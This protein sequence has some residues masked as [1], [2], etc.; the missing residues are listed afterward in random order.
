VNNLL[1]WKILRLSRLKDRALGDQQSSN[2]FLEEMWRENHGWCVSNPVNHLKSWVFQ[3]PFPQ[4][5]SQIF[6]INRKNICRKIPPQ[7][8]SM[9]LSS[10]VRQ[11]E[12]AKVFEEK[13]VV[14]VAMFVLFEQCWMRKI[15]LPN[16]KQM[17]QVGWVCKLTK[18]SLGWSIHL[19]S[20]PPF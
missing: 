1:R 16:V 3:L 14:G 20:F 18:I 13:N 7:N 11:P 19:R 10:L 9:S 4:L 15:S 6:S 17:R 2:R 12:N 5:V 8:R